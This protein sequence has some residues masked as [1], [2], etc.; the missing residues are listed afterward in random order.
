MPKYNNCYLRRYSLYIGEAITRIQARN[1][2]RRQ[3]Q[4]IMIHEH[5]LFNRIGG[6]MEILDEMYANDESRPESVLFKRFDENEMRQ[7]NLQ[8]VSDPIQPIYKRN[9]R[10]TQQHPQYPKFFYNNKDRHL[11]QTEELYQ[12]YNKDSNE[13]LDIFN[14]PKK[15]FFK[16]VGTQKE[17]H[18][19]DCSGEFKSYNLA[20]PQDSN[21]KNVSS[22]TI[23]K[24]KKTQ[25]VACQTDPIFEPLRNPYD[26]DESN[27]SNCT[28]TNASNKNLRDIASEIIE[29][30][31]ESDSDDDELIFL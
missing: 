11:R 17:F 19:K 2:R 15:Q 31:G 23:T 3:R 8:P 22:I 16:N 29:V 13:H 27:Q 26:K 5:V 7:R 12:D 1:F 4:P 21:R 20:F 18:E 10:Q 28:Q 30:F 14:M 25:D 24:I 6:Q 9:W